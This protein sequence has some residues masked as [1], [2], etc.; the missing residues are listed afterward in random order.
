M[1]S[2]CIPNVYLDRFIGLLSMIRQLKTSVELDKDGNGGWKFNVLHYFKLPGFSTGDAQF[3][4][5]ITLE[6][7]FHVFGSLAMHITLLKEYNS[8][9]PANWNQYILC[10]RMN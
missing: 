1:H 7:Y 5:F 6:R 3:R 10:V 8:N 9:N 4:Y 2:L